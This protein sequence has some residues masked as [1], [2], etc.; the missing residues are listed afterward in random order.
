[1]LHKL[2][3]VKRIKRDINLFLEKREQDWYDQQ[4]KLKKNKTE[5]LIERGKHRNNYIDKAV[6]KCQSWGGPFLCIDDIKVVISGK[7]DD[8]Q[9]KILRHEITFIK[10]TPPNDVLIKEKK[11]C[12][13]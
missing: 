5:E 13:L 1:M 2:S 8:D 6:A 11:S 9:Q 3:Q 4:Q 7:F 12:T 10:S